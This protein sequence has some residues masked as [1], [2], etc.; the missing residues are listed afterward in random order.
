M[1]ITKG[2]LTFDAEGMEGGVFHSRKLH[3]PS[4][5]S[6]LTIG[7]GYDMKEK[8]SQKIETDLNLAGVANRRAIILGRASKLSGNQA[9]QFIVDQSL[10][11]FEISIETQEKLFNISYNEMSADVQRIC[12]KPDCIKA[13]GEVNWN[14]L[15][16]AIKEVIVDLRYR[17]DYTPASRKL[18]QKMVAKNDIEQ[19]ILT[20]S[21]RELWGQVPEDRFNRRV[22]FC[23]KYSSSNEIQEIQGKN[24]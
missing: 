20:L 22:N 16:A 24:S 7:R 23:Q 4:D 12:N 8:S 10:E 13:Y 9:R 18:I 2:L 17:G 14:N 21:N 3:V 19:F 11:E 15:N 1:T 5:S 6:G